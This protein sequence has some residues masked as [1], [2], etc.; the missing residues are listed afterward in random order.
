M[1]IGF[2]VDMGVTDWMNCRLSCRCMITTK[3]GMVEFIDS[4]RLGWIIIGLR[5]DIDVTN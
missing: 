1:M 5:V 4:T 3:K 2:R